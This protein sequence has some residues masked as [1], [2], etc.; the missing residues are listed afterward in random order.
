MNKEAH[1]K[2]KEL[3]KSL[4]NKV[5]ETIEHI[6]D[7]YSNEDTPGFLNEGEAGEVNSD[8]QNARN[9]HLALLRNVEN[10]ISYFFIQVDETMNKVQ[11]PNEKEWL[12]NVEIEAGKLMDELNG[13]K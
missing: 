7:Q 3:K 8:Q 12:K 5:K 6:Y 11:F 1:A 9:T 10:R 2:V 13:L 4:E